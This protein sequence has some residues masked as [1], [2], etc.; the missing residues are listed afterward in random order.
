MRHY[1]AILHNNRIH[2]RPLAC[3]VCS[4]RR[5]DNPLTRALTTKKHQKIPS[6]PRVASLASLSVYSNKRFGCQQNYAKPCK[7]IFM[8][9]HEVYY[10][11]K[12]DHILGTF[13]FCFHLL[14]HCEK[15]T[16]TTAIG[17]A[18]IVKLTVEL[19]PCGKS[20]CHC[21]VESHYRKSQRMISADRNVHRVGGITHCPVI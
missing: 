1:D 10:G 15:N 19:R 2:H 11:Q 21:G 5:S 9:V 13:E 20:R 3:S 18:W 6:P 14:E 7:W 12:I 4:I 17:L 8:K 16:S